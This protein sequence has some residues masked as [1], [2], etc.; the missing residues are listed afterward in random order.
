MIKKT[1]DNKWKFA[2]GQGDYYTTGCLIDYV[3]L[4][5]KLQIWVNDKN[6]MLIRKQINKL[7]PLEIL[8]KMEIQQCFSLLKKQKK[9]L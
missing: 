8:N 5:W 6:L 7:I 1:Y 9:L 3:Y 2:T 4:R